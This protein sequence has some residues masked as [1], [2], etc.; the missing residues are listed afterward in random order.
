[1]NALPKKES[2]V[3]IGPVR[4]QEEESLEL[5]RGLEGTS[6]E[7]FISATSGGTRCGCTPRR[8][9]HPVEIPGAVML[10]A[11]NSHAGLETAL[12]NSPE[13]F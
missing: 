8:A 12:P 11:E 6:G 2:P 4:D 3:Y 13:V 10:L 7:L 5:K 9:L 1:V